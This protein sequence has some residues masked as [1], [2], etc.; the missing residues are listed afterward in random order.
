[1]QFYEFFIP[2]NSEFL[3]FI[4]LPPPPKKIVRVHY[5]NTQRDAIKFYY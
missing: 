1:M 2:A 4:Q 5:A 3:T